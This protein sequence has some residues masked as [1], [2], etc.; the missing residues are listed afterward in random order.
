MCHFLRRKAL[1]LT[2]CLAPLMALIST[3]P[4]FAED[5]KAPGPLTWEAEYVSDIS[6]IPSGPATGMRYTGYAS[7]AADLSLDEAIG[8]RGA[9]VF[10][11]AIGSVGGRPNDLAQTIQGIDNI[12]VSENRAKLFELYLEQQVVDGTTL[13]LGFSDLNA[14]F[15]KTEASGLLVAPA[16]GIGSEL[17]ATGPNGPSLFPSTALTARLR[18]EFGTGGYAQFAVINA[19]SGVI[20]DAAGVKPLFGKG[21]LLIGEIGTTQ[22]GSREGK[23]GIGGWTYSSKQE[24]IRLTT[25]TGDPQRNQAYGFYLIA[26]RVIV[27]NA[28]RGIILFG[29]AGFSDGTS[30]PYDGGWQAGLTAS[31][32]FASRPESQISL[33]VN[34]AF[35]SNR[36]RQNG[37]DNGQFIRPHETGLE[38][39]YSDNLAPWLSVQPDLQYVWNGERGPATSQTVVIGL[40][41]RLTAP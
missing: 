37:A 30:T 3:S 4:A 35:L 25:P 41:I 19:E 6:G 36:F 29:R 28:D 1:P 21:A 23:L 5:D 10:A 7:L 2:R 40:R 20:G 38:L 34:Q 32:V 15:Y 27:G 11:H 16:F 22:V 13:R 12:E 24:D 39:T 8:W 33:G 26:E 14:E 31:G 17:A 18:H 9:R